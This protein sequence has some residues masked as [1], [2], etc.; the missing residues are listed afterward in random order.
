VNE[1]TAVD[2]PTTAPIDRVGVANASG[3]IPRWRVVGGLGWKG[4][5]IGLSTTVDWLPAY[6]DANG[7]GA[8]G[9]R[10][11]ERTLVDF[12][13]TFTMQDLFG[14]GPLW[15]DLKL[16]V[17]VKNAFDEQP[18]FADIG[19]AIGFDSSQGD[20]IGRFGYIKLSKGF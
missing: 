6:W 18:P 5:G 13:A 11:P 8:T 9:R 17:G 14:S 19:Y 2:V 15:N 16:Q 12:Q 20:L 3:S 1:F 10:L 4:D 7:S